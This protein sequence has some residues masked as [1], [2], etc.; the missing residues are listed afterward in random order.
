[1][2]YKAKLDC[3][4]LD[5]D[6]ARR[7]IISEDRSDAPQDADAFIGASRVGARLKALNEWKLATGDEADLAERRREFREEFPGENAE[8]EVSAW[9]EAI[10]GAWG[11]GGFLEARKIAP[12]KLEERSRAASGFAELADQGAPP[13]AA[14]L[15]WYLDP[16]PERLAVYAK[17][18]LRGGAPVRAAA[19]LWAAD[20][21]GA[22]RDEAE[23]RAEKEL[24]R[25]RDKDR[26]PGREEADIW[27]L[28]TPD[29]GEARL[30]RIAISVAVLG[31][32]RRNEWRIGRL[33]DG[34]LFPIWLE[35]APDFREARRSG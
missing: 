33:R 34:R 17:A 9:L 8:M 4:A 29:I 32:C 6:V 22:L 12:L 19:L 7:K 25:L 14:A 20:A 11:A 16:R 13:L 1:M 35:T 23:A 30:S 10:L 15:A 3:L 31:L 21:G 2:E 24:S 5:N 28:L 27:R 26:D 18:L